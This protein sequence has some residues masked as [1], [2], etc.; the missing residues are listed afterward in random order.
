MHD[1]AGTITGHMKKQP[2]HPAAANPATTFPGHA[3]SHWGRFADRNRSAHFA[4][5][6]MY[7]HTKL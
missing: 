6:V 2:N 3:G 4:N 7:R 1:A 5:V